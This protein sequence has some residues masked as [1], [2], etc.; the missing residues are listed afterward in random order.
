MLESS[1]HS[2]QQLRQLLVGPAARIGYCFRYLLYMLLSFFG[3]LSYEDPIE[4]SGS[5]DNLNV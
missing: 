5:W 3:K 2:R 4:Y 1:Q